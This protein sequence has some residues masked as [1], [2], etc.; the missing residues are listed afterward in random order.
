MRASI[1]ALLIDLMRTSIE[2]MHALLDLMCAF[3]Q[4]FP[5]SI[6]LMTIICTISLRLLGY[7]MGAFF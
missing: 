2:L 6:Q 7:Q 1:I 4:S 5:S 3:I